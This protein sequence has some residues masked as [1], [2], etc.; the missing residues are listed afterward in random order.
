MDLLLDQ[1]PLDVCVGAVL[2]IR[3]GRE[4]AERRDQAEGKFKRSLA[5]FPLTYGTGSSLGVGSRE[6]AKVRRRGGAEHVRDG[7][8]QTPT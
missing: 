5:D 1:P 2:V 4:G 3:S 8:R 7:G 6:G